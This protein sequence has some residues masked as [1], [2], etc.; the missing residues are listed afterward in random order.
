[1]DLSVIIVTHNSAPFIE[2]C[3][4]SISRQ[5]KGLHHEIIV[6]DNDSSDNTPARVRQGFPEVFLMTNGS[7]LG[8]AAA[9]NSGLRRAKGEFVLFINPDTEWKRGN[10]KEAIQ[11][12]RD[13]RETGAVGCRLVLGDGS[14]Q[15]SCGHF[16]TLLRELREVFYL[17]RLFGEKPWSEGIFIY[18]EMEAGPVD[19]ASAAFLLIPNRVLSEVQG[20]DERY[21]MYYEDMDLSKKI[22]D[23]G[24]EICFYPS[25][26]ITHHQGMPPV[27]D[28][29]ESPYLYFGKH[30]GPPSAK[31]LRYVL[32][33]KALVRI[34]V[35]VPL[36]LLT[37]QKIFG[38]KLETN[39]RTFKYHLWEAPA[40]LNKL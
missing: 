4:S 23:S 16:P 6:V 35:F 2:G 21:F 11:F 19:W 18:G 20:F 39:Y 32:L 28:S 31:R 25:I 33:L 8:F 10:I 5:L 26:E 15:K 38:E 17:P 30:F 34:S 37:G 36:F 40:L 29:G 7:N 27:Y 22:R 14:W 3:L 12:L 9:N 24:R 13:H 1:M